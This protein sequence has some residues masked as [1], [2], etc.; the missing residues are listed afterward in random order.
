MQARKQNVSFPYMNNPRFNLT[1]F[2]LQLTR[3]PP[4]KNTL[5]FTL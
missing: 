4:S 2:N 1:I 3:V 5:Q